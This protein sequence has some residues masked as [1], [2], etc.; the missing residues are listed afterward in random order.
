[1]KQVQ[2]WIK[3][4]LLLCLLCLFA[5]AS[6][7]VASVEVSAKNSY[8]Y[9]QARLLND[10]DSLE[11]E[12]DRLR[13]RLRV[14]IVVV[15]T[16][17][18]R[19][20]SAQAYADDFYDDHGFGY[21]RPRGDG[22]LFL[23]DMDNREAYIST[24][25]GAIYYFTDSRIDRALDDIVK[26]LKRQDYDG[27]CKEFLK[28]TKQFMEHDPYGQPSYGERLIRILQKH[29]GMLLGLSVVISCIVVGC[30]AYGERN[31]KVAAKAYLSA[32]KGMRITTRIDT[33]ISEVTTSRKIPQNNDHDS[34]GSGGSSMHSS[35]SGTTH[36]GGGRSF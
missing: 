29:W 3:G 31:R 19:G 16:N 8:V 18:T 21:N 22:A 27:A 7:S 26:A 5:V 14:D 36:G 25:G 32:D 35:S 10:V 1:M 4:S 30:M 28:Y 17:D 11:N 12:I 23:I 13:T 2:N 6:L 33:L 34:R 24:C 20:K 9:D 15:T